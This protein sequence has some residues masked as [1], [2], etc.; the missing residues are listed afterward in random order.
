MLSQEYLEVAPLRHPMPAEVAVDE[1]RCRDIQAAL[2]QRR[3]AYS[4]A[5]D[6]LSTQAALLTETAAWLVATL[7]AGR[8]VLVAGNGGS[9]AQSQHFAAELVGRFKHDRAPYAALALTTDTATL[10]A[11][12]NDYGYPDVFAR[13]VLAFGQRGDLLLAFSTSGESENLLRAAAACQA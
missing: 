8:R 4:K 11:V 9:A 12:A 1:K 10:T 7:R 13:Q 5:M 3:T 2:A 6:A